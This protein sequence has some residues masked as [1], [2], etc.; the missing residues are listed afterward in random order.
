MIPKELDFYP[1]DWQRVKDEQLQVLR[2]EI[3]KGRSER[4]EL[5]L[6][7]IRSEARSVEERRGFVEKETRLKEEMVQAKRQ[8][9]NRLVDELK[10]IMESNQKLIAAADA[11]ICQADE[12]V[13]REKKLIAQLEEN[14]HEARNTVEELQGDR[15]EKQT[16]LEHALEVKAVVDDAW[17][18]QNISD[19]NPT[20]PEVEMFIARYHDMIKTLK[21]LG[22]ENDN[23]LKEVHNQS[24]RI[25]RLPSAF[26][27]EQVNAVA[28]RRL[29]DQPTRDSEVKETLHRLTD[30]E[31]HQLEKLSHLDTSLRHILAKSAESCVLPYRRKS[32]NAS[33][34]PNSSTDQLI[35]TL[36]ERFEDLQVLMKET[37]FISTRDTHGTTQFDAPASPREV[38]I[39]K[40]YEMTSLNA[41]NSRRASTLR[42]QSYLE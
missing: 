9:L 13:S 18:R 35:A 38:Q 34:A 27:E 28:R 37:A 21:S 6:L 41:K 32:L 25:K 20:D 16:A 36:H 8:N 40:A 30:E 29:R 1:N 23:L 12:R 4:S 42:T 24:T 5:Q 22:S 33:N 11:K 26:D 14:V 3:A 2:D 7:K 19:C 15:R 31:R 17:R 10:E 39:I